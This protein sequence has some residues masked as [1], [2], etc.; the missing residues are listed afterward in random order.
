MAAYSNTTQNVP[1]DLEWKR[2]LTRNYCSSSAV[3]NW[4]PARSI[5]TARQLESF[6][7]I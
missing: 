4:G 6:P 5:T 7:A 1:S 3:E 2:W